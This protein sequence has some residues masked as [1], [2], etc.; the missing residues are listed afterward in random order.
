MSREYRLFLEDIRDSCQKI[1][2]YT[3]NL[4]F[5]QF[6]NNEMA[7]DAILRN[8]EIVGEAA[9]QIPETVR[10]QY[11]EADW[12]RIAGLRDIVAHQYFGIHDEIIWDVVV[13]KIP[14][15]LHQI[16]DILEQEG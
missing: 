6:V 16:Q 10:N 9:K 5:K 15:L 11:P 1:L 12:R 13:N 3:E 2:N 14:V 7:Y 8:V 4:S